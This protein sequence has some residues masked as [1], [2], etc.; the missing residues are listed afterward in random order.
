MYFFWVDCEMTGLDF[1]RDHVLELACIIT[2]ANMN[3]V[4]EYQAVIYHD[5]TVLGEMN[6]WC[7]K[8]HGGSGLIDL[9][10][11]SNKKYGQVVDDIMILLRKYAE[12]KNTYIAGNSVY[13]D[14]LF[15]KKHMFE[16]ADFLHYR[17]FD[18]SSFKILAAIKNIPP[19]VKENTHTAM[20]DIQESIAE[21]R[22]YEKNAIC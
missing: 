7:Q 1:D 22:Y 20:K 19:Y 13:N 10:R 18:I 17:I 21:Y 3:T 6:E 16:I 4:A 2:D 8:I 14:L 5:D 11:S 12:Q 15:I 9:V